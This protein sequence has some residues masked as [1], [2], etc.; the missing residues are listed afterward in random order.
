MDRA[1]INDLSLPLPLLLPVL[2]TLFPAFAAPSIAI[3]TNTLVRRTRRR[4]KNRLIFKDVHGYFNRT[5]FLLFLSI[6]L[7]SA[8]TITLLATHAAGSYPIQCPLR[9]TWTEL[10][11]AKDTKIKRIQN[12][13]T[14][15]GFKTIKDMAYPFKNS[16]GL[17]QPDLCFLETK[18]NDPCLPFLEEAVQQV[19]GRLILS[20]CVAIFGGVAV[21]SWILYR[22][23]SSDRRA[24]MQDSS[25]RQIEYDIVDDHAHGTLAIS[26]QIPDEEDQGRLSDA[27]DGDD[28]DD[29]RR[30]SGFSGL[31]ESS[32]EFDRERNEHTPLLE[33]REYRPRV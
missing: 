6:F 5:T 22:E 27:H 7:Y 11:K 29:R 23:E 3:I 19:L 16:T 26:S 12:E 20:V 17:Y 1:R 18:R 21:G 13:L 4:L 8:V 9:D 31:L 24:L 33:E 32:T 14:C 15:C 30:N 28:E 10:W 2:S 25:N